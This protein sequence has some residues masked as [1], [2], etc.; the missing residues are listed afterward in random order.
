MIGGRVCEQIPRWTEL[1]RPLGEGAVAEAVASVM[2]TGGFCQLK[3]LNAQPGNG[4]RVL[5]WLLRDQVPEKTR[6]KMSS[7]WRK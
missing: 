7:T 1:S 3:A 2:S 5:G 4:N 6:L